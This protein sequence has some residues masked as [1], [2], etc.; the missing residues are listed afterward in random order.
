M[1]QPCLELSLL[2]DQTFSGKGARATYQRGRWHALQH[3]QYNRLDTAARLTGQRN[4]VIEF[5][6]T[7][8]VVRLD[9]EQPALQLPSQAPDFK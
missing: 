1:S 8:V 7:R 9:Q 5:D 3:N 4:T 2:L 6:Y